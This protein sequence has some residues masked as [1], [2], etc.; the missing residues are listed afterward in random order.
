M[1]NKHIDWCGIKTAY[2]TGSKSYAD[3]AVE[4]NISKGSI[5]LRARKEKW[6]DARAAFRNK[7]V[8][9]VVSKRA[10]SEALGLV[11]LLGAA[12]HMA[13]ALSDALQDERKFLHS[14]S[15]GADVSDDGEKLDTRAIRDLTVSLKN[16][17]QVLRSL[18]RLPTQ[19]EAEAQKLAREKFEY[20]KEKAAGDQADQTVTVSLG[21][22]EVYA[23]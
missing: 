1:K 17:A 6:G 7:V 19:A 18:Y 4:M 23:R 2:V 8:D 21:D 10:D 16:M 20:Q 9:Q 3:L 5:A 14:I 12:E 15:P 22:A 13:D 11:K